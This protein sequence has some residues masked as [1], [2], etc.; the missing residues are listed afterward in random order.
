VFKEIKTIVPILVGKIF[1]RNTMPRP[2]YI[3]C[4]YDPKK[5]E[6]LEWQKK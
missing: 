2:T 5:E 1:L 3:E 6:V 4:P